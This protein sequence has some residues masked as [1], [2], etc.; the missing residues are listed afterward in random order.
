MYIPS[1]IDNLNLNGAQFNNFVPN[2]NA[3]NPPPIIVED[4]FNRRLLE[5][6]KSN[7][8]SNEFYKKVFSQGGQACRLYGLPKV[9]KKTVPLRPIASINGS[10]YESLSRELYSIVS[11]LPESQIRCPQRQMLV[12]DICQ[13]PVNSH[14]VSYDVTSLF[15]NVPLKESIEIT[16]D[17]LD[18]QN[19]LPS[20]MDKATMRILL[21]LA[22]ENCLL[23]FNGSYYTQCDGV[24]MGSAL[25]PAL[26]NIMMSKLE[27]SMSAV[28]DSAFY[29]T[30]YVD[31]CFMI[32]PDNMESSLVLDAWNNAHGNISFTM[33]EENKN[34]LS[35]LDILI[36]RGSSSYETDYYVKPT[37]TGLILNYNAV[38]PLKYKI[39]LIKGM[40]HRI[41]SLVSDQFHFQK[42]LC[43]VKEKLFRNQYPMSFINPIINDTVKSIS[44]KT[45]NEYSNDSLHQFFIEYRGAQT[46]NLF[47]SLRKYIPESAKVNYIYQLRKLRSF[48][49]IKS[50]LP[51]EV[52]SGVVYKFECG[53]CSATY[54][55]KSDTQLSRRIS[56][57]RYNG[58]ISEHKQECNTYEP[59]FQILANAHK[60]KLS[61]A[62]GIYISK[63][64]PSLNKKEEK[65]YTIILPTTI[66]DLKNAKPCKS[67]PH[68]IYCPPNDCGSSKP[69][70]ASNN[71]TPLCTP[72]K[73]NIKKKPYKSDYVASTDSP[74]FNTRTKS[75]QRCTFAEY[76]SPRPSQPSSNWLGLEE[77]L[78]GKFSIQNVIGD[79]NCFYYS[80]CDQLSRKSI[81]IPYQEIKRQTSTF[82]S[83]GILNSLPSYTTIDEQLLAHNI[84]KDNAWIPNE[85]S[86]LAVSLIFGLEI[87]IYMYNSS[88]SKCATIK[89][90]ASN[91]NIPI[92]IGYVNSS[93]YVS[94]VEDHPQ[95]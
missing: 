59:T 93:H 13:I 12:N 11:V 80:I 54:I 70:N 24:A 1:A 37:D 67:N 91:G 81:R 55:G 50:I 71:S 41:F 16:I 9:H 7:R 36:T 20:D 26:A 88:S 32:L 21:L 53:G 60:F 65:G 25:G 85:E 47:Q 69:K 68:N 52:K 38:C 5:L 15:T 45:V 2:N 51:V 75:I 31:D 72:L 3:K 90:N 43:S 8:I 63:L 40:V 92:N 49:S 83:L 84:G 77:E 22:T 18:K 28:I 89:M 34:Q 95:H 76:L 56:R 29:Y 14:M 94:L 30:R 33:E 82:V 78:R 39:S 86:I 6:S 46:S 79:G 19:S 23:E 35:F 87:N 74:A 4:R 44:N 61:I 27:S 73:P 42:A 10:I 62:E 58:S 57:H 66:L 17:L 64:R 48:W